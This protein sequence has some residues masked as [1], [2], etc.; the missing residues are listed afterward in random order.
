MNK[1]VWLAAGVR[2]EQKMEDYSGREIGVID[3]KGP[4]EPC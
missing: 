1:L 3:C 4:W 2:V